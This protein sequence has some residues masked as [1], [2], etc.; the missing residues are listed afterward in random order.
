MRTEVILNRAFQI[1]LLISGLAPAAAL[2]QEANQPKTEQVQTDKAQAPQKQTEQKETSSPA[3]TALGM[4][5]VGNHEAPKALVLVPWKPSEPGKTPEIS[6]KVDD[7]R[8]PID[9]EV[10]MR[11]LQYHEIAR[12]NAAPHDTAAAPRRNQ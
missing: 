3:E 4:S 8:T 7:S 2:A 12:T 10:F 11:M 5:I 9:K 1:L 6:T